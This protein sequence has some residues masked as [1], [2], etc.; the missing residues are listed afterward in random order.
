MADLFDLEHQY[1]LY[2]KRMALPENKMHP[3]QKLETKRAFFGAC[4]QMLLMLRDDLPKLS[5]EDGYNKLDGMINQV[6]QFFINETHK[7]N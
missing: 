3:Q 1:Q 5:D 7:Q 4:G 6:G 2:L